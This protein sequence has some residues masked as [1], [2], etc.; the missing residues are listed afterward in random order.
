MDRTPAILIAALLWS[1]AGLLIKYISW[2]P[3]ACVRPEPAGHPRFHPVFPQETLGQGQLDHA[4]V[5]NRP[6]SDPVIFLIANKLTTATNAIMLQYTTPIFIVI[7]AMLYLNIG[8]MKKVEACLPDAAVCLSADQP[9][10]P[11]T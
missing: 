2:H 1:T 11:H 7:S 8:K 4:S 3:M 10:T 6:G 9:G 5:R